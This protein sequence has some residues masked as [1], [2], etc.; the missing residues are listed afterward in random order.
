VLVGSGMLLP[1][2]LEGPGGLTRTHF[3]ALLLPGNGTIPISHIVIVMQEN[4]VYDTY[5][6]S[7]CQT[8]G[9]YC[10]VNGTGIPAGTCVPLNPA[11]LSQGCQAPYLAPLSALTAPNDLIHDWPAA[12]TAYDNGSMDGFYQAESKQLSTFLY[13]NGAEIPTYWDLA[14]QYGLGDNFFA[15]ALSYSTPNHWYLVAGTAPPEGINQTLHR[16]AAGSTVL[17]DDEQS[18]LNEANATPTIANLLANS[19][20]SWK[21]YDYPLSTYNQAINDAPGA[22]TQHSAFDFWNPLAAIASSYNASTKPH[23]VASSQFFTDAAAGALPNVSWVLPTFNNSDHPPSNINNGESWV[24][25]IVNA[26]E[27]SPDWNSTAVFVTW[28]DYGGYYDHVPPPP[29][30]AIGVS[31]RAPLLVISPYARE[32]YI[33]HHFT[34]FESLLHLIEWRF[35][36]RSLTARDANAP[37]PLDYFDFNATPR[38]PE[39]VAPPPFAVYPTPL[40]GLGAPRAPQALTASPGPASVT[41][42]WTLSAAG[43]AVTTYQL[44]YGPASDPTLSTVR[45]DG[46][47]TSITLSNLA[48]GTSYQFS[49]ASI[50]GGN[51]SSAVTA[52]AVPLAGTASQPPG[53]PATWTALP[54]STGPAPA[55]RSGAAF[56]Y[57]AADHADLL[58]GGIGSSGQYLGDTWEFIGGHWVA[59]GSRSAPSARADAGIAFDTADNL[60]ILFGGQGPHGALGDTWRFVGG[61]WTN[62]SNAVSHA[63][64]VPSARSSPALTDNPA[65]NGVLLFGG[66]GPSGALGDTWRYHLGR[67][68]QLNLKT[69]PSARWG[70]AMAYDAKDGYPVL[71]GGNSSN[72][73]LLNDTWKYSVG[74]WHRVTGLASPGPRLGATMVY[75]GVDQYL[76]LFGGDGPSSLASG[77]WR[78][79]GGAWA[80]LTPSSAPA[81]RQFASGT[82]DVLH[83]GVVFGFGATPAGP[84]G[85]LSEFGLPLAVGLSSSPGFADVPVIETFFPTVTGGSVPYRFSWTFG[86]GNSSTLIDATHLYTTPGSHLATARVTDGLG[87]VQTASQLVV[88]DAGLVASASASPPSANGTVGFRSTV[89][90]GVAP[91]QYAWSFGDSADGTSTLADPTYQYL[92]PGAYFATVQVTDADDVTSSASVSVNTNA[93]PLAVTIAANTTQGA[94][95]LAVAFNATV[96]NGTGPCTYVWSFGDGSAN[97]TAV[98]PDHNFTSLG[99]FVVAVN[100]TNATGAW[101]TSFLGITVV[102]G[103]HIDAVASAGGMARHHSVQFGVSVAGGQAPYSVH[104]IFGDGSVSD[105]LHPSHAFAAA[106][107]FTV[108][109]TVTDGIGLREAAVLLVPVAPAPSPGGSPAASPTPAASIPPVAGPSAPLS[110]LSTPMG[111]LG[112]ARWSALAP[113]TAARRARPSERR[114]CTGFVSV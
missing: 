36:L 42:N 69:Q 49:L 27:S 112:L 12:H 93:G 97:S 81:L 73:S 90:G 38:A 23:F 68:T 78:Y 22:G 62:I 86:D 55:A 102:A 76:V 71:T 1:S 74:A 110:A 25:R 35:H 6:G 10:N 18:Y 85:D 39:L 7:Y 48:A 61:T 28:D 107:T 75:D 5:F 32:G 82:Y 114:P 54:S 30:D 57:D 103:L 37:L 3:S 92:A 63:G 45:E 98:A 72:G 58:F 109:V 17:T 106:G 60:V 15:S 9:A 89:A 50:T 67:W 51:A 47:L 40:Q 11:N 100:V 95:S 83:Q 20:V 113:I 46:S 34:Y 104:W 108:A 4:H 59:I 19:S 26:V 31:F 8:I 105:A 101:G 2:S 91:Y 88:A 44:T 96:P 66:L 43:A 21:Y 70:A 94:A 53:Q 24:S 80:L 84:L 99:H 111:P 77:T 87:A 65:S 13:Y 41:L 56:V 52:V 16:N 79:V 29:L 33:S 14:E 64:A